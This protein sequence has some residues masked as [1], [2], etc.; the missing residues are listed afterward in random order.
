MDSS[1]VYT[2]KAS[3]T[4]WWELVTSL[5]YPAVLG[6]IMYSLLILATQW[7]ADGNS[8]SWAFQSLGLPRYL[9]IGLTV[10]FTGA[11]CWHF[12]ADYM[13]T[14]YSEAT[15]GLLH[16]LSDLATCVSLAG[17]YNIFTRLIVGTADEALLGLVWLWAAMAAI[18]IAFIVW[19][20]TD[21]VHSERAGAAHQ[22]FWE[23]IRF[24]VGALVVM[25]ILAGIGVQSRTLEWLRW[26]FIAASLVGLFVLA[27]WLWRETQSLRSALK[28]GLKGAEIISDG[29]CSIRAA[30][31]RD[32]KAAAELF[33]SA[34]RAVYGEIWSIDAA[35]ERLTEILRVDSRFCLVS[36]DDHGL[37]AF[38]FARPFTWYQGKCLWI[39]EAVVREDVRGHGLGSALVCRL[40]REAGQAGITGGFSLHARE[41][42]EVLEWYQRLGFSRSTWSH[43]ERSFV[44]EEENAPSQHE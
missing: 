36:Y 12:S 11:I 5:I 25:V 30:R 4:V 13:Y 38:L 29:K 31:E 1:E 28:G 42:S 23:M 24:E 41:E 18:Y 27:A 6:T 43:W 3:P 17:G 32:I 39:E 33:S 14:K 40:Q 16:F 34:Y 35:A 9:S 15:Y 2:E 20:A 26:P 8:S 7:T 19:D 22:F 21:Y 10:L 44:A 37:A